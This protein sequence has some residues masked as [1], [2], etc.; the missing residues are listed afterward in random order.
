MHRHHADGAGFGLQLTLDLLS[1]DLDIEQEALQCRRDMMR[2]F[3]RALQQLLKRIA[4]FRAK[5]REYAQ[6]PG[7]ARVRRFQR[8]T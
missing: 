2:E 3:Q 7:N 8:P 5:P 1:V 4:R 6:P